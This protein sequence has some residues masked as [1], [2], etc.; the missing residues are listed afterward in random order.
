M[1]S[2]DKPPAQFEQRPAGGDAT[3]A[4]QTLRQQAEG[5]FPEKAARSPLDPEALSPEATR[6]MVHELQVHQIELEMQN[7]EL[8]ESQAALDGAR[9][10]YFDLYD[11]APVGYCTVSEQGLILQ[12]NL[13]LAGL[14]GVARGVLV[15]QPFSRMI[16]KLDQDTYYLLRKQ[17]VVGGEPRS[18]ELRMLKQFGAQ[19]WAHLTATVARQDGAQVL[20]IVLSDISERKRVEAQRERLDQAL[21]NK[22]VELASATLAAEKAN[23][24]KSDFLSSMSHE[25]R[26]PLHAILG[27]AQLIEAGAPEPTP[28]QKRSIDQ[29]LK[30]GWHLLELINEILDLSV[31][32]SGKLSLLLEPVSLAEVLAECE[33]MME[34]QAQTS[35]IRVAMGKLGTGC[36]VNAE[37]LR[38][39]QVLI[40]LLTNAIKYNKAGGA[41]AVECTARPP[42]SIRISVRDTGA[43]L[44]PKQLAQLFQPFNR[45]GQDARAEEGTGIGLVVS[46]RLIELMGGEIGVES[47]LGEGSVFWIELK[48]TTEPRALAEAAKP[49]APT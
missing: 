32:E 25:L 12:C 19:C 15:N 23:Q 3:A 20:R 13:T 28:A 42:D 47:T 6:Q 7:E 36:F 44:A 49:A 41:V 9:A 8:R 38:L 43:G 29:I 5:R 10:R 45:L 40:N 39:K 17:L 33:L 4:A 22:N 31:I 46:K 30:A 18:C 37:R 16:L 24:A 48:R 34:P 21:R 2:R 27:F 11:L 35:G 26:T 1:D 14:L